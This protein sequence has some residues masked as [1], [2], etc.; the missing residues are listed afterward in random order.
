MLYFYG[1]HILFSLFYYIFLT[2]FLIN[3]C[4]NI[5]TVRLESLSAK[6]D[7]IDWSFYKQHVS[8]PG[9]VEAFEKSVGE[10]VQAIPVQV[11]TV[12]FCSAISTE[13]SLCIY[14]LRE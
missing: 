1:I 14:S 8:K 6:P 9:F 3:P 11:C 2:W 7:P 13:F 10:T 5:L 12:I 4:L